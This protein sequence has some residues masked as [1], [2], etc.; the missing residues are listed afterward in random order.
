MNFSSQLRPGEVVV[1]NAE[2]EKRQHDAAI[3]PAPPI[4]EE[5]KPRMICQRDEC[6][7]VGEFHVRDRQAIRAIRTKWGI[8]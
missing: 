6:A 8:T 2:I 4:S 1:W 7:D 5:S 3:K